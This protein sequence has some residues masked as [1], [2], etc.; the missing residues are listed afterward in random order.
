[1]V[2]TRVMMTLIN[3]LHD[4]KT[5]QWVL[6]KVDEMNLEDT[7]I[8]VEA[9]EVDKHSVMILIG[10]LTS[11]QVNMVNVHDTLTRAPV[12]TVA[13][14]AMVDCPA[15]GKTCMKYKQKSHVT[16]S[17]TRKGDKKEEPPKD[18]SMTGKVSRLRMSQTTQDLM[19]KQENV[20]R[21]RDEV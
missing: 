18:A 16:R 4:G 14:R 6:S 8:F 10:G 13:R 9:S 21:L 7:I 12:P 15:W 17:C 11:S 19:N 20:K 1:M 3:G 2:A 5:Q